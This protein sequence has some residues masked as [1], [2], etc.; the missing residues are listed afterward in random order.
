MNIFA[1]D[2]DPVI[3][4]RK[5]CW[6][7]H[8]VKMPTESAQMLS[9]AIRIFYEQYDDNQCGGLF[10]FAKSYAMNPCSKW[11]RESSA[12]FMW[13]YNYSIEL[14]R[15]YTEYYDRRHESQYTIE[16]ALDYYYSDLFTQHE[17]TPF[18]CAMPTIYYADGL[19]KTKQTL[20]Q[21]IQSY[22]NYY[23]FEKLKD[24]SESE[25]TH[26]ASYLL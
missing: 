5:T 20:E 24:K 3:A 9:Y 16:T 13:L 1:L 21:S 25:L 18:Y 23:K 19:Y 7:R 2:I 11:V 12:N 14:C 8:I 26:Y 4:A 22:I 6:K 17:L 10:K 15:I